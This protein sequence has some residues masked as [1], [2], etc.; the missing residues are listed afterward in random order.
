MAA[1]ASWIPPM[2]AQL[3]KSPPADLSGW[4]FERKFD[5][6][7]AVAVRNGD[8]VELWSRGHLRY[9]QRFPHLLEELRRL[10][11]DGF[12]LDGE[13]VA[14][15]GAHP[16]FELLQRRGSTAPAVYEVFDVLHL[17]GRDT[18]SLPLADR[19][20]LL[21][22]LVVPTETLRRVE[23]LDGDPSA[24]LEQACREGWEGL[25]A[26]RADGA[27][28]SGR[29]PDWRK[30]KCEAGQELV[31][32]GW[33]DPRGSRSDLGALLVGYH[34]DDGRLRYAGKVGTG[35]DRPTLRDLRARLAPIARQG[36]PF[37]DPPRERAVHW[38]EPVLV[39]EIGFAEWT[40]DGKLRHP[41]YKGLREDK[42]PGAV[43]RERR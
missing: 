30:L 35:F 3:T 38:V 31:I 14:F 43:V 34:D 15:A 17:L 2:L 19:R 1:R 41:R 39:A 23:F 20:R 36:P 33:T 9:D 10:P 37:S 32:G 22:G 11:A 4:V 42:P 16:S 28:R 8:E 5:G 24:L 29:S 26:K 7:R 21:E 6:L 12:T 13:I 27:Y 25:I 40:P 18:T